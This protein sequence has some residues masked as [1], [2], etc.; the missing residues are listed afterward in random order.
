MVTQDEGKQMQLTLTKADRNYIHDRLLGILSTYCNGLSG[1][2]TGAQ[3]AD[4]LGMYDDRRVQLV[5]RELIAEGYPIASS[6][7]QPMGYYITKTKKEAEGYINV[8]K[9]RMNE[10]QAR[11]TDYH[12]ALQKACIDKVKYTT[13][14]GQI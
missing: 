5:I 10:I 4:A 6:V 1:A 7:V 2:K 8:L 3:L 11:L 12:I 13:T 14:T 9:G